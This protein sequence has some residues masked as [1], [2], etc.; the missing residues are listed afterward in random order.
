MKEK[1]KCCDK[2]INILI[3]TVISSIGGGILGAFAYYGQWL[4]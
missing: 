3:C 4:G 1:I 2:P